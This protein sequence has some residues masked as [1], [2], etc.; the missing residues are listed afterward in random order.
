M[1]R[2]SYLARIDEVFE[3]HSV[4]ALL[5][6]RQCGKTTIA[7]QYA[8][9]YKESV[10]I[11]D[12]EDPLD[13][14]R[15]Q[16]PK[17]ALEPLNGLIIID[18]IQRQP[19]LFPMLRVLVDK[20]NKKF[21]ILGSA[22]REL[23][24]QSSE[25]LAGRIA[26][27]EVT[28]FALTEIKDIN[29]L[30]VRG[31]YPKS[32]LANTLT[33]SINW[34]KS[35]IRT[36]LEQDI[37]ALGFDVSPETIRRFWQMLAHYHGQIFNASSIANSIQVTNKTAS[38]YLDIL[39]GTFMIRRLPAWHENIKKRQVK[40][41][42]IYF[43]DNGILL[44]LLGITDNITTHPK[45]G[46]CWEGMA[47]EEIIRF[48]QLET[49]DCYFWSAGSGAELDLL[50]F[51]DGRKIGFEFKYSDSPKVT[52]S[53]HIAIEDLKLDELNIIIPASTR[54]KI[55]D[56]IIVSGLEVFLGRE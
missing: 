15:L 9:I 54:F 1:L 2:E 20:Y 21:L 23:I 5:G 31:G 45:L 47:L 46:A 39:V 24:R 40:S 27:I 37:R 12:L 48:L 53:M 8:S 4:C 49:E 52:K 38:R 36:F 42:K 16:N 50:V 55:A 51:K 14:S 7:N 30:F 25:S 32:F 41:P 28:P 29:K 3:I 18:E 10:H 43:R 56:N 6:P 13:L 11:F 44:L 33:Q 22:S 19:E 17:L 26:Y 34:R 35:Y